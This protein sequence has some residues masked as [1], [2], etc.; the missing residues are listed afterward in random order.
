MGNK[1]SYFVL[2]ISTCTLLVIGLG[3][4][5]YI[6][7]NN[8]FLKEFVNSNLLNVLGVTLA[9]TLASIANVHFA[10][11]R[12]EAHYK[13]LGYLNGSRAALRKATYWL[14]GI[15]V[16]ACIVVITK[17]VAISSPTSEAIYNMA[18]LVCLIWHVLILLSI[19][20]LIFSILPD[21]SDFGG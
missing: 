18:A 6:S 14:I 2:F 15:F 5:H 3:S 21:D 11:N 8:T 13:K 16:A 17:P 4:P 10:F 12:M 1:E 7:D 9:I 19:T 20:R